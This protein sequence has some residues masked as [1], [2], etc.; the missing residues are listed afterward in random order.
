MDPQPLQLAG[1]LQAFRALHAAPEP[2]VHVHL[3]EHAHVISGR[4]HHAADHQLHQAHPVLQASAETVAAVVGIRREELADEVAVA[5]VDLDA[6][7]A[8]C[9]GEFHRMAEILHQGQDLVFA[10][11]AHESR[12]I[13]VE[14]RRRAHG[15]APAG[16]PVGHVAAVPQLDGRLRPLGV[17][18][19]RDVPQRRDDLLAHPELAVERQAAPAHGSIGE[20]GHPHPAPGHG[21]MVIFQVLRRLVAV[22]H[23]LERSRA[24]DPVAQGHGADPDR[25]EDGR[26]DLG[27][28][29]SR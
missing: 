17:D 21:H 19:V 14:S 24:D 25:G 18:G 2:V 12:R 8:R 9:A 23:V 7:E 13:Q 1:D 4:L 20:R 6:V 27:H 3:D 11:G 16:R 15:H 10:Q 28:R 29:A 22:G 26:F 5:R